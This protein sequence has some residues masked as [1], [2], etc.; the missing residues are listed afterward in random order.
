MMPNTIDS[1]IARTAFIPS[2]RSEITVL[3]IVATA[4]SPAIILMN[5]SSRPISMSRF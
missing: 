4:T 1:P 2:P 3:A 5:G